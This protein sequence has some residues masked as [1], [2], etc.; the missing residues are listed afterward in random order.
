MTNIDPPLD[1]KTYGNR[2]AFFELL[3]SKPLLHLAED[4]RILDRPYLNLQTDFGFTS[5]SELISVAEPSTLHP[6][7]N[8]K[9]MA[10]INVVD[11]VFVR[12]RKEVFVAE[13]ESDQDFNYIPYTGE[14]SVISSGSRLYMVSEFQD[15]EFGLSLTPFRDQGSIIEVGVY[16]ARWQRP[17]SRELDIDEFGNDVYYNVYHAV[18]D[19]WGI[20][21]G[22]SGVAWKQ[23]EDGKLMESFRAGYYVKGGGGKLKLSSDYEQLLPSTPEDTGFTNTE[24]GAY[25]RYYWRITSSLDFGVDVKYIYQ[26]TGLTG[27]VDVH[28]RRITSDH[29]VYLTALVQFAP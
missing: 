27:N 21:F 1:V 3:Y 22:A 17:R 28:D 4:L 18:Q 16:H 10:Q 23:D 29:T 19:F 9:L 6:P 25:C 15:A 8:M 7:G 13:L 24:I 2:M 26:Y 5:S 11:P 20:L 14:P 12:Y